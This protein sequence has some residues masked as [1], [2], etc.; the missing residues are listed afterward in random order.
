MKKV[1]TKKY[2]LKKRIIVFLG[3][4]ILFVISVYKIG[5]FYLDA[6]KNKEET[7]KIIEEVI[8]QEYVEDDMG[9]TQEVFKIDFE[10]LKAQNSSVKGWIYLW[11]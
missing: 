2:K 8:T 4:F 11:W 10:S 7:Q 9:N 1:R 5:S 6:H 3:F